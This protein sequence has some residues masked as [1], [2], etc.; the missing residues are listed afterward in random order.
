MHSRSGMNQF[1]DL[2]DWDKHL[3]RDS[4]AALMAE[5]DLFSRMRYASGEIVVSS[6]F[7]S[8]LVREFNEPGFIDLFR[9]VVGASGKDAS[10]FR[11]I[12]IPPRWI[13]FGGEKTFRDLFERLLKFGVFALGLYRCGEAAVRRQTKC[14]ESVRQ[15]SQDTRTNNRRNLSEQF[16]AFDEMQSLIDTFQDDGHSYRCRTTDRILEYEEVGPGENVLP[17]VYTLPDP[18]TLLSASDG[19]FVFCSP[20]VEIPNI[21]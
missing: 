14:T 20:S 2:D 11:L 4:S 1:D 13:D 12:D 7:I 15:V 17:Y 9:L 8:L 5:D 19:V 3:S 18:F 10:W 16:V 6:L 21:W